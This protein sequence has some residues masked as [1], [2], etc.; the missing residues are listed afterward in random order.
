MVN[1]ATVA[2][3]PS[4]ALMAEPAPKPLGRMAASDGVAVLAASKPSGGGGGRMRAP[5]QQDR[6][7]GDSAE[8]G[9]GASVTSEV[10]KPKRMVHYTGSLRL[11]AT[12]PAELLGHAAKAC[13]ERGGYVESLTAT[14]MVLRV[15]VLKFREL[16]EALLALGEVVSRSVS[17][18]DVT[19]A[20]MAMELRA[21]ILKAS[22]D[23]LVTLLG[24]ATTARAKLDLLS[25]IKRLTDEV[26]QLDRA[27]TQYQA[28]ALYSRIELAV[29]PRQVDVR[30]RGDEPIA[31]FRFIHDLNPFK[32]GVASAN[33][34][35]SLQVPDGMVQ[36]E[37]GDQRFFDA[38]WVAESADGAR[39]W[40]SQN[41]PSVTGSTDFW[42]ATIRERLGREY[43]TAEVSSAGGF[44]VLRL[45]DDATADSYRYLVAVRADGKWLQLVEVYYP[46]AEQEKRF[47]AAVI[48]SLQ[49]GES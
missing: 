8:G 24:K 28:L 38:C 34:W 39:I 30:S 42:I 25:E 37:R 45:V 43:A 19:D 27:L 10:P 21:R 13:E 5:A 16:Y 40:A 44:K 14:T 26:D 17:A 2:A 41:K 22:R 3:A 47:S 15:P 46:N 1:E 9:K 18:A 12:L 20:F 32:E 29:E 11:R 35:L 31:A 7:P 48:A 6:A 33:H 36:P 4:P 23:R 49:R